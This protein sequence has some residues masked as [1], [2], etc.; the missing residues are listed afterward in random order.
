LRELVAKKLLEVK[1]INSEN[2]TSDIT[3][4]NIPGALHKKHTTNIKKGHLNCWKEDA[5]TDKAKIHIE[6]ES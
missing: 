3:T 2:N 1:F 4:R 6:K 5:H